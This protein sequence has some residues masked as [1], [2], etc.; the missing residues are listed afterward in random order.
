M[1]TVKELID[2]QKVIRDEL[3]R[4]DADPELT[5]ED[6]GDL[7]DSLIEEYEKLDARLK[8]VVERMDKIRGIERAGRA[9][10]TGREAGDAGDAGTDTWGEHRA[11]EFMQR[12]DPFT[13]LDKV[14]QGM[15]PGRDM[16]SRAMTMVE[17]DDRRGRLF[18]DRG[19]EATR[20]A[21]MHPLIARHMLLTGYD[22]YVEAF[23]TYLNDPMGEGQ[24]A[25]R[26]LALGTA[27]AG[28]LLPYVLDPTIVIT[29]S[30]STNPYRRIAE[31]KTTTTNAWHGANSAGITSAWLDEAGTAA[32]VSTPVGAV[33]IF[34]KKAAAWIVGSFEVMSDTN[35][36]EQLPTMLSDEK[37]I[38]EEAGFA[39][40]TGGNTDNTGQPQGI[41]TGLATAQRV[42]AGNVGTA[43]GVL[44]GTAIDPVNDI[45]NLNAALGA[46]FR[47][48]RSVGWV[49]NITTINKIR[50]LDKYGGGSF[51]ANLGDG[52]PQRLLDNPLNESPSIASPGTAGASPVVIYGD[53][54]KYYI[55]DRAGSTMLFDP[56]IKAASAANQ[57]T[58]QQGWFYYW[59]VGA[60]LAAQN[61]FRYLANATA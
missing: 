46:R 1:A 43:G 54:S 44:G 31:V 10:G 16:I 32:E 61:A 22:D 29:N 39:I 35:Y 52:Q 28:Y 6:G 15:V 51:L 55:V 7:R 47:L 18:G 12:M 38:R 4:M 59:R 42:L 60:G 33:T 17:G 57:P 49:A 11:P 5:E 36:A 9:T 45:Y 34:A 3:A 56:L 50:A 53:W 25:V 37:D 41:A 24:A 26:A 21:N 58:G 23:R 13:D 48:S 40:G 30:G 19:E 20:K 2:R 8:P 27:S 14:R